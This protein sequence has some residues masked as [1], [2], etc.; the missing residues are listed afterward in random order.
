MET[1]TEKKSKYEYQE[2]NFMFY[3]HI[4]GF[5]NHFST[6]ALKGALPKGQN[7]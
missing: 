2:G 1:K 5:G 6:E 4:S 7:A 3:V